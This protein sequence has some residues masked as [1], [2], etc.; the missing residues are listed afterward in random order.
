[1]N[2]KFKD[3]LYYLK[4]LARKQKPIS[5]SNLKIVTNDCGYYYFF[6][7][8]TRNKRFEVFTRN[9]HIATLTVDIINDLEVV[10][11]CCRYVQGVPDLNYSVID[12][13]LS[14]NKSSVRY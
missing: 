14:L 12:G 3:F 13:K 5:L 8:E 9:K 1:M 2:P 10:I 6:D 11:K 4:E 7:T